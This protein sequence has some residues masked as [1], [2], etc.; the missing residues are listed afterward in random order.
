MHE[1]ATIAESGE[2]W[3]MYTALPPHA[4][5]LFP[6]RSQWSNIIVAPK[7]TLIFQQN[8]TVLFNY[9]ALARSTALI[10]AYYNYPNLIRYATYI[11]NH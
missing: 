8:C 9:D 5:K 3:I 10:D 11:Q 6:W 1:A 4:E 7:L 2:G